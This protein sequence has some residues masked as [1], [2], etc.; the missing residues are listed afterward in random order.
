MDPFI[1]ISLRR[2]LCVFNRVCR[3]FLFAALLLSPP[4]NP[5]VAK[6]S[7]R[8]H[9]HTRAPRKSFTLI[10]SRA[11]CLF[12]PRFIRFLYLFYTPLPDANG[13]ACSPP[14]LREQQ[15]TRRARRAN[16]CTRM[17]ARG[18]MGEGFRYVCV[19]VCVCLCAS[20]GPSE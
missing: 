18:R 8:T 5:K 17:R 10:P 13:F 4:G 19:C 2:C 15:G 16:S 14:K 12:I 20:A 6:A 11:S 1:Y 9:T 7:T 3:V